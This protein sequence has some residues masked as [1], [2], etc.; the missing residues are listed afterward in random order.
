[1]LLLRHW[2]ITTLILCLNASLSSAQSIPCPTAK[3]QKVYTEPPQLFLDLAA[4]VTQPIMYRNSG[5]LESHFR[6]GGRPG[7]YLAATGHMKYRTGFELTLGVEILHN[8]QGLVLNYNEGNTSIRESG[9]TSSFVFRLP[10]GIGYYIRPSWT[11]NASAFIAYT[12]FWSY[13]NSGR[14]STTGGGNGTITSQYQWEVPDAYNTFYPGITLS[15][16]ASIYQ[17]LSAKAFCSMDFGQATPNAGKISIGQDGQTQNLQANLEPWL[18]NVG[19]A[20][21]YRLGKMQE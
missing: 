5:E 20:L 17:R 3:R 12:T 9:Y 1:M 18:M 6:F 16:Q 8:Q 13:T 2:L 21:S 7:P 4:G 19:I 11:L 15:T 14:Q 10:V